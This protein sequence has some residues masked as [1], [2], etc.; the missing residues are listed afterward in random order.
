MHPHTFFL[1]A[2]SMILVTA[3]LMSLLRWVQLYLN[4]AEVSWKI[5]AK[6][7]VGTATMISLSISLL[8]GGLSA[9]EKH[10]VVLSLI[11]GRLLNMAQVRFIWKIMFADAYEYMFLILLGLAAAFLG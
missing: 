3:V 9:D 7:L 8:V 2:S 1:V 6:L 11:Y 5:V 10:I 4:R